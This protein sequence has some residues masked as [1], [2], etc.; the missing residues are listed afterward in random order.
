M[1][2]QIRGTEHNK[3]KAA[4]ND[5]DISSSISSELEE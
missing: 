3:K 2:C 1:G 4:L 5:G